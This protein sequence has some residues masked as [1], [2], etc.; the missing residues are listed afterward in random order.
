MQA[1][2][3]AGGMG[4]RLAVV[5]GGVP[6]PMAPVAGIPFLDHLVTLVRAGGVRDVV[7]LTGH[8]AD[9]IRRHFGNGRRSG[10]SLAY[11]REPRPLGT[12]GALRRALPLVR[13]DRVLLINGDTWFAPDHARLWR[14]SGPGRC[15]VAVRPSKK[16]GRY[17][18]VRIE[19]SGRVTGWK[20]RVA[21][22]DPGYRH[23]N[24]GVYCIGR[25]LIRAM[26]S[27]PSSLEERILPGWVA[28]HRV[29]GVSSRGSFL[30]IGVPPDYRRAQRLIPAW[31]RRIEPAH[32]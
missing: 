1:F 12:G 15:V 9:A 22:G 21:R 29:W 3:L 11:S 24:A 23:I 2:I 20:S 7:L 5:L 10:I 18:G 32:V 19:R 4:R 28:D 26:P 17:G 16:G 13:A 30:D 31:R 25:D 14:M 8:G 6:K 27:G